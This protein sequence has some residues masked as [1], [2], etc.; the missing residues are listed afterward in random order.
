MNYQIL[1]DFIK[2]IVK[3]VKIGLN[4]T[5]FGVAT[6]SDLDKFQLHINFSSYS[7]TSE[8]VEAVQRIPYDG[9]D[10][11][12]GN[13][14]NRIRTELFSQSRNGIPKI[15]I[16]ITDGQSQDSVETP[17]S[18]LRAMKVHIMSVGIGDVVYTELANMATDP[19]NQNVFTANFSSIHD[20]VGSI[21]ENNCRGKHKMS[22]GE[23]GLLM[24][25]SWGI[26]ARTHLN[27][28]EAKFGHVGA[29]KSFTNVIPHLSPEYRMLLLLLLLNRNVDEC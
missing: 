26:G 10:T 5:D 6:Y 19:D 2:A 1:K 12:T 27:P 24:G 4:E 23:G 16:V 18:S 14:L 17:S 7:N 22:L 15:L 21:I 28:K 11:Y 13:G 20:V 8:I 3:S 29:T 9:G 25:V